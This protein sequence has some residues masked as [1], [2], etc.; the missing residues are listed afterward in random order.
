MVGGPDQLK[1]LQERVKKAFRLEAPKLHPDTG[2]DPDSMIEV[3]AFRDFVRGLKIKP[4]IQRPTVTITFG[5]ARTGSFWFDAG[6]TITGSTT[7]WSTVW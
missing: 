6:S 2:G 1:D 4:R 7:T 3:L 5:T